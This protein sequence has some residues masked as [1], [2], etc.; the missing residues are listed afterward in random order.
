[1][2]DELSARNLSEVS[3]RSFNFLFVVV[4]YIVLAIVASAWEFWS[5]G[6]FLHSFEISRPGTA[7]AWILSAIFVALYF[8]ISILLTRFT[9]WGRRL[10]TMFSRVLTP[11]SY[12]QILVIAILSGFVEEWFFRGVL[13]S[14]FGVILSSILF[15][16]C[17]FIPQPK[18]W[19][20]SLWSF[21][22]GVILAL[23][24]NATQSIWICIF[25]HCTV[26]ALMILYLNLRAYQEPQMEAS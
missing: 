13:L 8:F 17:H 22:M 20:W 1:L 6:S 4:G 18:L 23:I 16:L 24:M 9:F 10:D 19:I 26:N 11:L 2:T 3:H 25:I 14:H 12:F 21:A 5:Q 15:G 7:F